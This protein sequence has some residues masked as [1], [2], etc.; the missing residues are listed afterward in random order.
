MAEAILKDLLR[1][2]GKEHHYRV[3]SAG[4]WTHDGLRASPHAIRAMEQMGLDISTHRSRHLTPQDVT[5]SDLIIVM[6]RDHNEALS[7]EFPEARE[8]LRLLSELAGQRYDIADPSG[9]GS[10]QLHTRCATEIKQL[11]AQ[12]YRRILNLAASDED[13]G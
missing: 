4:T 2:D 9:S 11:L 12:A 1:Q 3:H 8:K 6:T 7:S 13:E 10:L 5:G